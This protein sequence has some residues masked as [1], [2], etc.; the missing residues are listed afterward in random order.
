MGLLVGTQRALL[1]GGKL[2][3]I[4]K[5]LK[6][7]P[8]AYWP[9]NET[10]GVTAVCQVNSAQ[11]GTYINATLADGTAPDGS[12]CPRFD[13]ATDFVNIWST[14]F[15]D[16]FDANSGTLVIW[17]MVFNAGVWTDAANR[18]LCRLGADGNNYVY[19]LKTNV[20]DLSTYRHRR[21]GT[22]SQAANI[23]SPTDWI[24][25]AL[26][27]NK[28][29]NELKAYEDAVQVGGTQTMA[30][31]WVGNLANNQTVLGADNIGGTSSYNGWL[32]HAI[33]F[34]SPLAQVALTDLA[35]V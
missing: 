6:L 26:V 10:G 21:S 35:T 24:C 34:N 18:Y 23:A 22:S 5:V 17:S 29:A 15:R 1:G 19:F 2:S 25:R 20:N 12:P 4:D 32:A 16:A 27:W 11:N 3:Y 9:L 28:T 7:S 14:V 31:V 33:C 8:I 13:G 30:N